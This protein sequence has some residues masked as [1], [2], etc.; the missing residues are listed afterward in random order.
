MMLS[1]HG[2]TV[3][4]YAGG[5]KSALE[6]APS[7]ALCVQQI[8]DVLSGHS[9][10]SGTGKSR[11]GLHAVIE[12]WPGIAH[13][14]ANFNRRIRGAACDLGGRDGR[15]AVGSGRKQGGGESVTSHQIQCA[16]GRWAKGRAVK[17]SLLAKFLAEVQKGSTGL[18]IL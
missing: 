8:A 12:V 14:G 16:R 11:S 6:P 1:A 2:E 17:V 5:R 13:D 7:D 4:V 3:H 9:N 15:T 10:L 18:P